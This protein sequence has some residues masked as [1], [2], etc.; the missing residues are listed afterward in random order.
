M[1]EGGRKSLT[2]VSAWQRIWKDART[3]LL[4]KDFEATLDSNPDVI[5]IADG[6]L[7]DL[8]TGLSRDREPDDRCSVASACRL[9]PDT[10]P[11]T[12]AEK[13]FSS[14]M[15]E[16]QDLME[17]IQ[18]VCG[19]LLTGRRD[20]RCIYVAWGPQASNGKSTLLDLLCR[21]LG[22]KLFKTVSPDVIVKNKSKRAQGSH[23]SY[24]LPLKGARVASLS[25]TESGN[26]L[27]V[28]LLKEVS[29]ETGVLSVRECHGKQ[30]EIVP[31]AKVVVATNHILHFDPN[32]QGMVDRLVV[33]PFKARF[34]NEPASSKGE[35]QRDPNFIS[36]LQTTFLNE[37]FTWMVNG[38]RKFYALLDEGKRIPRPAI[39]METFY[40][41]IGLQNHMHTFMREALELCDVDEENMKS[42]EALT[43]P[44]LL[45][46]Y[47]QWCHRKG[48]TPL[49][50]K[51]A[52]AAFRI[53]L[54]V[55]I[56]PRDTIYLCRLKPESSLEKI[57]DLEAR[58][59]VLLM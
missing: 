48:I 54:R 43:Q 52:L 45:V 40:Q 53:V 3:D 51:H 38:A 34:V 11:L 10:Y 50:I 35:Y 46:A 30:E 23:S 14:L 6:K 16:Q 41:Y 57:D 42:S 59:Q 5:A 12:N 24:L 49:E 13:F 18:T 37:V 9:L 21:I 1:I 2:T 47:Q 27:N 31:Q 20:E 44:Q 55:V 29:S 22:P 17:Y 7:L 33:I 32:D 8:R 25:E 28:A 39:I 15:T 56:T 4:D 19:Y 58:F 26:E 36:Q